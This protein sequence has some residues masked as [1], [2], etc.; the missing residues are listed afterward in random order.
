[1]LV[2]GAPAPRPRPRPAPPSR[3]PSASLRP[4]RRPWPAPLI[5]SPTESS[6]ILRER[7]PRAGPRSSER[8]LRGLEGRGAARSSDL[9]G[10]RRTAEA[11]GADANG[12]RDGRSRGGWEL[13]G[14]G[15]GTLPLGPA[16]LIGPLFFSPHPVFQTLHAAAPSLDAS[17]EGRKT[18]VLV[19]LVLPGGR[20]RSFPTLPHGELRL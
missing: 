10:G 9:A 6:S 8:E 2:L 19:V 20:L 12:R 4:R 11:P 16:G 7:E 15:R 13:G 14:L 5:S 18:W 17:P 3:S 1:M